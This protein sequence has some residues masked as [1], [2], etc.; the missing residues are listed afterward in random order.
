[1]KYGSMDEKVKHL[2]KIKSYLN[3][4]KDIQSTND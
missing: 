2:L 4:Q 3:N 1:M